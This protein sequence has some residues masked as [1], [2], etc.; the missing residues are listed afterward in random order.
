VILPQKPPPSARAFAVL[1]RSAGMYDM[2]KAVSMR[3]QVLHIEGFDGAHYLV[4]FLGVLNYRLAD[5]IESMAEPEH[6]E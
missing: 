1:A 6:A 2:V 5:L 3:D 4:W